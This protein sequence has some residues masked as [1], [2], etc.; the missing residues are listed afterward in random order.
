[1]SNIDHLL[2][3]AEN[4]DELILKLIWSEKLYIPDGKGGSEEI[5]SP[6]YCR[7]CLNPK[8]GDHKKECWIWNLILE[9]NK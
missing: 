2:Q 9:Y 5:K 1:M 8:G 6:P 7:G 3:V 4:R